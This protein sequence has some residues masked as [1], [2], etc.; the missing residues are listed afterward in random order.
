MVKI[1][2]PTFYFSF[3]LHLA[4]ILAAAPQGSSLKRL[5]CGERVGKADQGRRR[6]S[7]ITCAFRRRRDLPGDWRCSSCGCCGCH[8]SSRCGSQGDEWGVPSPSRQS[9]AP[10]ASAWVSRQHSPGG[11]Q[12]STHKLI[13][14]ECLR[15]FCFD[16]QRWS[17]AAFTTVLL[18]GQWL[19]LKVS[20]WSG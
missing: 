16:N 17:A 1:Q 12:T 8:R 10:V 15:G 11:W 6:L 19:V 2:D 7:Q 13:I 14:I 5:C 20:L 9:A 4:S 18:R 3:L